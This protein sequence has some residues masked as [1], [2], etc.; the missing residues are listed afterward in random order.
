ML[1][2]ECWF[3][4]V[5]GTQHELEAALLNRGNAFDAKYNVS[6]KVIPL[7]SRQKFAQW[8][9]HKMK[10]LLKEVLELARHS[11]LVVATCA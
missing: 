2:V 4:R 7:A 6:R 9:S 3:A 8:I 11:P 5:M 10:I 1:D